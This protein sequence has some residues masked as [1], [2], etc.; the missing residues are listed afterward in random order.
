MS[1]PSTVYATTS[2]T[3]DYKTYLDFVLAMENRKEPQVLVLCHVRHVPT[4]TSS[5]SLLHA[6]FCLS[7]HNNKALQYLFRLLD[8]RGQGYLDSFTLGYFFRVS[9][10]DEWGGWVQSH[11]NEFSSVCAWPNVGVN[12]NPHLCVGYRLYKT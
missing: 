1:P 3:Q 12:C 5:L 4:K 7:W 11:V 8:I 10:Q 2:Q 6:M 9:V